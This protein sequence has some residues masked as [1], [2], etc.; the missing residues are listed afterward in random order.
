ML[1]NNCISYVVSCIGSIV[2]SEEMLNFPNVKTLR[3]KY[4]ECEKSRNYMLYR[5][6]N[7][8]AVHDVSI[9]ESPGVALPDFIKK[10]KQQQQQYFQK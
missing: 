8:L 9:Y 2:R 5:I 7:A 3:V 6:I 4:Y 10:K 1:K